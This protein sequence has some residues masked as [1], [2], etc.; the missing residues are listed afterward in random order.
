MNISQLKAGD[1]LLYK[2][3]GLYGFIIRLKTWHP[4]G[5]V[6][7]FVGNGQS[8]ASRD[9]LGVGIYPARTADLVKVLRPDVPFQR[10]A[11]LDWFY[12]NANHL[13]YGWLDLLQFTGL[14][15][16]RRGIVCSP[17]AVRFLRAG[18]VPVLNGEVAEKVAPFELALD[19][20]L[21]PVWTA[22]EE[23]TMSSFWKALGKILVKAGIYAVGHQNVVAQVVADAK[24]KNVPAILQDA[25]NV[26]ADV[27]PQA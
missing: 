10:A 22:S 16:D 24:A 17:F 23:T 21:K 20:Y 9:G 15:V 13:P 7:V 3:T 6:E 4:E 25:A 2:G 5:H 11:A 8:A 18:G 12:H 26:A 1:V 27:K 19:D 14:N